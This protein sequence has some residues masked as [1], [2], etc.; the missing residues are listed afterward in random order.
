MQMTT[1]LLALALCA[2]SGV[3]AA[4]RATLTGDQREK[5]MQHHRLGW[6]Y[7]AHESW[8]D[9]RDEFQKTLAI[10]SEM[11]S[12][13]YGLGKAFMGQK[14]YARAVT[15]FAAARDAY[16]SQAG[17]AM[18]DQM[19][20]NQR[21][22]DQILEL[23]EALREQQAAVSRTQSPSGTRA[24]Q[25]LQDAIRQLQDQ[26]NGRS[27]SPALDVPAEI[28]LSLGSANF[29]LDQVDEAERAYTDALRV[30]PDFG[31]AH[32]NMAVI[33]LMK[34]RLD[35]AENHVKKA[36]KAGV[37]VNPQLKDDIKHARTGP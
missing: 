11:P 36:E 1:A 32:N 22:R 29:R 13:L 34:G 25:N 33:C 3:L 24:V 37:R 17:D 5:A 16:R 19:A 26:I 8:D 6:Q 31:E 35:E 15:A 23:K 4:Q 9:A 21:R 27:V 28:Y 10:W 30:R 14:D 12:A 2:V 7:L 18:T 20:M